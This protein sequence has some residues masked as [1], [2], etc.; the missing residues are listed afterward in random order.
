MSA[1]GGAV[2]YVGPAEGRLLSEPLEHFVALFD[3]KSG[4]THLLTDP[5][6]QL[7]ALLGAGTMTAQALARRLT[8]RFDLAGQ[9]DP[10][11]LVA[12][13]LHELAEQGLVRRIAP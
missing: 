3:R 4:Q 10:A 8:E 12:A 13:R 6:P 1:A 5:A 11:E 7:L 9:D 2:A